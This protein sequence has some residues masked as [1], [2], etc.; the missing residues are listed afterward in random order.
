MQEHHNDNEEEEKRAFDLALAKLL[1]DASLQDDTM[2]QYSGNSNSA[3][4]YSANNQTPSSG[5]RD[6]DRG[7][8]PQ[9]IASASSMT[10][11]SYSGS[12]NRRVSHATVSSSGH[13]ASCSH[14]GAAVPSATSTT[15]SSSK[16]TYNNNNNNNNNHQLPSPI[17]T[18]LEALSP[19]QPGQGLSPGLLPSCE[20][21][22]LMGPRVRSGSMQSG[23]VCSSS[24][25][26]DE[27]DEDLGGG[28]ALT[29]SSLAAL[30]QGICP[31]HHRHRHYHP[32]HHNSSNNS[33]TSGNVLDIYSTYPYNHRN[34]L[35]LFEDQAEPA[36]SLEALKALVPSQ[37]RCRLAYHLDEC[38]LVEFSPSGEYLAS[39]GPDQVVILW[40][41]LL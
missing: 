21:C 7:P 41:D 34:S 27:G 26:L 31:H 37:I 12:M 32:H 3:S 16:K 35:H 28:A 23:S 22:S 24:C 20:G 15:S 10:S 13:G 6:S 29:A 9:S 14:C 5:A 1:G 11:S 38:W 40:G 25:F 36:V 19:L 33:Q 2:S 39:T 4:Y 17:S 30:N 8:R 18:E